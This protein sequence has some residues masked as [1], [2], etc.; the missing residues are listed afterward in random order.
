MRLAMT[1]AV[2]GLSGDAIQFARAVRRPVD[3][4]FDG[5]G[6]NAGSAAPNTCGKPG[7]TASPL[8]W[9]LPRNR[10]NVGGGFAPI[11]VTA[12]AFSAEL[13]GRGTSTSGPLLE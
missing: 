13:L 7:S 12:S 8:T 10:T 5:V 2:S 1:R 4:V 3:F 11:S 9:G 6:E